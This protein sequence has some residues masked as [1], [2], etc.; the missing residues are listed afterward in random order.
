MSTVDPEVA[1]HEF[2]RLCRARRINL[3]AMTEE[4][5]ETFAELRNDIVSRIV[6]G[7]IAIDENGVVTMRIGGDKPTS[8]TFGRLTAAMLMTGT[9]ANGKPKDDV[10]KLNSVI[11]S[12][13]GKPPVEIGKLD[14]VDWKACGALVRLFLAAK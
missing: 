5:S 12:I 4:E 7:D 13:T 6:S 3:D 1:V 2:E 8:Y 9:H 10:E 11:A 14:I